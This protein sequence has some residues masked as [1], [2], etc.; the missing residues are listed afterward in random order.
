MRID[1]ETIPEPGVRVGASEIAVTPV[2]PQAAVSIVSGM[3]VVP[4]TSGPLQAEATGGLGAPSIGNEGLPNAEGVLNFNAYKHFQ[5]MNPPNPE[6]RN[7]FLQFLEKV[8]KVFIVDVK[9]GSL[10]ITVECTSLEIL[11]GLWGDYCSGHL[12]EMAQKYLVTGGVLE[13]FGIKGTKLTTTILEEE[14]RVCR[15][16]FLQSLGEYAILYPEN[17]NLF[18]SSS[19]SIV[20]LILSSN[21]KTIKLIK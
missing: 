15:D 19:L 17:C 4:M 7:G 11:E 14:Y 13:E 21:N 3:A 9:Q 20:E 5:S 2:E 18:S 6:K 10:K 16:Y 8:R 12:N 1:Y